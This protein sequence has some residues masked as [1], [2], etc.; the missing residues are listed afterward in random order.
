MALAV[1]LLAAAGVMI[2]SFLNIYRADLGVNAANVLTVSIDLPA[3]KYPSA[4]RW[5]SFY[6]RLEGRLEAIPGVESIAIADRLPTKG[7]RRLPY[8]LAGASSVDEPRPML[9]AL[10]VGPAYFATLGAAIL[11][12]REFNDADGES[13]LA[14]ALVN[15]QFA[16]THW[17]GENAL[18]QRLRLFAGQTPQEWLTVVGV[19]S[20]IEQDARTPHAFDPLIYLPYRQ[21]PVKS[22]DMV[23]RTRVSPETLRTVFRREIQAVDSDLPV[24]GPFTLA[25][26]LETIGATD[27]MEC[28]F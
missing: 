5:V 24:F 10:T 6:E 8:E 26:R 18:G 28:C 19:V 22:M 16:S 27:Y 25:E 20:N 3:T 9:G 11:S 14:V 4:D 1:V 23:A 2:R 21:R 13:Q 17:P 12:G 7:V 15:Q